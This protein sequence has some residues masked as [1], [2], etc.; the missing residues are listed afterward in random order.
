MVKPP[1]SSYFTATSCRWWSLVNPPLSSSFMGPSWRR[2]SLVNPPRP[3]FFMPSGRWSPLRPM[4]GGGR[5]VMPWRVRARTRARTRPGSEVWRN[6]NDQLINYWT[7]YVS[8]VIL[9]LILMQ[10][11]QYNSGIFSVQRYYWLHQIFSQTCWW[12]WSCLMIVIGWVSFF[13]HGAF[14]G[15][16]SGNRSDLHTWSFGN[17]PGKWG[18]RL[19]IWSHHF[20]LQDWRK[21]WTG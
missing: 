6:S 14:W 9:K 10:T 1:S 15:W 20:F 17:K 5:T 8:Q 2:M 4:V 18:Q 7:F 3:S 21:Q 11:S 13:F 19:R 12:V 16:V